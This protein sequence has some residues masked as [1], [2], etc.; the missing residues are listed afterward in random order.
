MRFLITGASGF[1]G[2]ALATSLAAIHGRAALQLVASPVPRTE[3]ER[4]RLQALHDDGYDVLE[5][6]LLGGA[7]DADAFRHFDV[8]FHLAAFTETETRSSLV[9]VNDVGTRRLLDCLGEHLRG[10]LVVYTSSV[11]V[12]DCVGSTDVPRT[13]YARTKLVGERV[14]R[15]AAER[16]G[17][18]W[19]IVRLP[20]VI[21]P[22]Y[23]PGGMFSVVACG[24]RG[25]RLSTRLAWPGRISL[26][27]LDDA[28]RALAAIAAEMGESGMHSLGAPNPPPF[29][30]LIEEVSEVLHVRRERIVLPAC[31]WAF[32]RWFTCLPWQHVLPYGLWAGVWRISNVAADS[33]VLDGAPLNE[34]LKLRHLP[35]R[36]AVQRTYE[37]L[38]LAMEN[39]QA[40]Q[41][42]SRCAPVN[43][44][45]GEQRRR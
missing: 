21:G 42:P 22:G 24:L 40:S 27:F 43:S 16:G 20:T 11:T 45:A 15:D 7:L 34:L 23:R 14:V 9:R 17:A 19:K 6:D 35:L 18:T 3:E 5:S 4:G 44:R 38:R 39:P 29:D 10:K 26:V 41:A 36:D 33:M 28:V 13:E 12:T 30:E 25:N 37:P 32:V 2:Y 31:F 8:C 1:V